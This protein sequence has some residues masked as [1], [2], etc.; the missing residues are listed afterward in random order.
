MSIY[1]L[2][3]TSVATRKVSDEDLKG[4]LVKSRQNNLALNITGML[5]YLDP[6]FMQILEG[7]ESIIDEK[8]KKILNNE[9]HHKVSLIYKKPIKERSFSKWTMGFNKIGIEYFEDAEN[10][11]E[12]YKNDAFKKH[13]KEVIE[14]L[15]MFNDE[16]L[17]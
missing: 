4:L 6:Y 3:F 11:I 13:P 10:L 7:D 12:I 14:L 2:V 17:F 5:L 15:K 16:T 1:C 9:M 8:F